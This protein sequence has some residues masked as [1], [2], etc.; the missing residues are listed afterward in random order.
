MRVALVTPYGATKSD[1]FAVGTSHKL[2]A[3]HKVTFGNV[4][5]DRIQQGKSSESIGEA[6]RI[7]YQLPAGDFE[8]IDVEVEIRD[9]VF[10]ITPVKVKYAHKLKTREL[11]RID[12]PLTFTKA[13]ISP[14]W[15]EQLVSVNTAQP[16]IVAWALQEICRVIGDHRSVSRI[17]HIQEADLLRASGPLKHLGVSLGAYVGKGYDCLSDFRFLKYPSYSIPVEV[18]KKSSGFKYQ[19]RKYGKDELSRAIVLCGF[20]DHRTM[21]SH[22]DVIELDALCSYAQNFP[23][24]ARI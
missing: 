19:Q 6:I 4:G 20:H 21:S 3:H 11:R 23:V 5:H 17:A 24:T 10:Y 1:Y 7:W 16:G 2:D 8:R 18:K 15:T 14:L 13:Y 12:H 9:D 22:I